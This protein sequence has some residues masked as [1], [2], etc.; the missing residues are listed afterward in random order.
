MVLMY[1]III[2][3]EIVEIIKIRDE[4]SVEEYIKDNYSQFNI[5]VKW[6]KLIY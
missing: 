6:E 1:K 2:G 4:Y 3:N 5:D